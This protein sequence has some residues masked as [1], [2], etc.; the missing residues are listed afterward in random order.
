M[1]I[2]DLI[3]KMRLWCILAELHQLLYILYYMVYIN[4][5]VRFFNVNLSLHLFVIFIYEYYNIKY[6]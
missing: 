4:I 6:K 3:V 2:Y 5:N 1:Y